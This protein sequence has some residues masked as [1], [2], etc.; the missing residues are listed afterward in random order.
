MDGPN[1]IFASSS[2]QATSA[3]AQYTVITTTI[4]YG[5]AFGLPIYSETEIT[6]QIG[7]RTRPRELST[8]TVPACFDCTVAS[9][10]TSLVQTSTDSSSQSIQTTPIAQSTTT[11]AGI[12]AGQNA[13][14]LTS[15]H[16]SNGISGGAIAAAV[17]VPIIAVAAII[18][19]ILFFLRRRKQRR[20][21]RQAS[22]VYGTNDGPTREM[23]MAET[24]NKPVDNGPPTLNHIVP[25]VLAKEAGSPETPAPRRPSGPSAV[26]RKPVPGA[27]P[28]PSTPQLGQSVLSPIS[29]A[30]E[31]SSSR[32]PFATPTPGSTTQNTP[33]DGPNFLASAAND[34]TPSRVIPGPYRQDELFMAQPD[35]G[36]VGRHW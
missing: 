10:E 1:V 30:K 19:G 12:L 27:A 7:P 15:Q 11:T 33:E 13:A 8:A 31:P 14:P 23:A 24:N 26:V 3:Q 21:A 22:T 17:I 28:N 5:W 9:V 29:T 34:S 4:T 18:A 36:A 25:G 35:T 20:A 6:S 16:H 2:A 32:D